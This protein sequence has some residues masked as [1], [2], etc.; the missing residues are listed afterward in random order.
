MSKKEHLEL[1]G[2][3]L[4]YDIMESDIT[5]A[6]MDV[7][8]I[9]TEGVRG[10]MQGMDGGSAGVRDDQHGDEAKDNP[11]SP[12]HMQEHELG[13]GEVAMTKE[14]CAKLLQ[15]VVAQ[16]PDEEKLEA[17][18][19][20]LVNA[21]NKEDRTLDVADI[22]M[23]MGEIKAAHAGHDEGSEEDAEL[24]QAMGHEEEPAGDME[25][26][27]ACEGCGQYEDQA[28][29]DEKEPK[30]GAKRHEDKEY[31]LMD[32]EGDE[33]EEGEGSS[34]PISDQKT[35]GKGPGGGS[36]DEYGQK[37]TDEIIPEYPDGGERGSLGPVTDSNPMPS[38]GSGKNINEAWMAAIPGVHLGSGDP[39]DPEIEA[40]DPDAE[41]KM[42]KRRAGMKD[43]WKV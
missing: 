37:A 14:L 35:K 38:E 40:D 28:E 16:S 23:I 2:E 11:G 10:D 3:D 30:G 39:N 4:A 43:W 22:G 41:L 34:K 33:L 26:E 32:E 20:G 25:E 5:I 18:C 21:G 42:I 1:T 9:L 8:G 36:A 6:D 17:I 31:Q 24:D 12:L 19:M 27:E 13:Q 7:E 15:A 29:G